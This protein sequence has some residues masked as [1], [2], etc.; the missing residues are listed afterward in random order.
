MIDKEDRAARVNCG[1]GNGM[2][3]AFEFFDPS[4]GCGHCRHRSR[5]W[6]RIRPNVE[7][8]EFTFPNLEVVR[9]VLYR[10]L[11]GELAGPQKRSAP[12]FVARRVAMLGVYVNVAKMNLGRTEQSGRCG[13]RSVAARDSIRVVVAEGDVL[14]SGDF[15]R[16]GFSAG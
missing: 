13:C 5:D 12:A 11:V 1:A 15:Q 14:R 9:D 3:A 2:E 10:I 7:H 16:H 6:C 8:G 4:T